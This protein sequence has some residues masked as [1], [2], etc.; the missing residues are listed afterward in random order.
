MKKTDKRLKVIRQTLRSLSAAELGHAAG[1][2]LNETTVLTLVK[3][4]DVSYGR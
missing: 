1:G 2:D 3:K 4:N